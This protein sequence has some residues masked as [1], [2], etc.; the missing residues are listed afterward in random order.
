M[1]RYTPSAVAALAAAALLTAACTD[2]ASGPTALRPAAGPLRVKD[3]TTAGSARLLACEPPEAEERT[4]ALVGPLG[5]TVR[6][7][8]TSVEVPAGALLDATL[9][10]VVAPASGVVEY[11]IH[12][13]GV[14][15]F[16]FERPVTVTLDFARCAA[17]LP[18]NAKGEG[19]YLYREP[20]EV[21]EH[22][23]GTVDREARTLTFTTGHLSGYAVAF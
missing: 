15:H 23:G 18:P 11:E 22:M 1:R 16:Q 9:L 14:S 20:Y 17:A 3:R 4:V 6:L 19:V 13:V 21:L 2:V 5:G 12:A 8:N 10:E 7:G